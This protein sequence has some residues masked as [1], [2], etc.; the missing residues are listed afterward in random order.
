MN[1]RR[2]AKVRVG[3]SNPVERNLCRIGLPWSKKEVFLVRGIPKKEMCH[4]GIQK[5]RRAGLCDKL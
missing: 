1:L 4:V 2:E 3:R 5:Q